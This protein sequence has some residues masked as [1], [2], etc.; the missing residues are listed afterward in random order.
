MTRDKSTETLGALLTRSDYRMALALFVTALALRIPFRSQLAYHWDSAQ[1]A[2]AVSEYNIRLNQPHPPGFYFYIFLARLLNF[3]IGEP[4]AALVWL[5]VIAG[6]GLAAMGYLLATSMFGSGCGRGTGLILLTSPLCWFQSEIA[7]TTIVDG[8]LVVSFVFVCWRAIQRKMTWFQTFAMAAAFAAVGGVRQQSAVLLIPLWIY[9]FWTSAQPRIAKVFCGT[10][11]AAG[12]CLLWFLPMVKS[13]GGIGAYLG[14]VHLKNQYD[15]PLTVWGGG[16]VDALLT[17]VSS[18]G[19]ACWVGLLG[20]GIISVIEFTRWIFFREPIVRTSF[21]RAN[22]TQFAVLVLWITPMVLFGLIMYSVLPGH[23]LHFFPGFAV[24]ASL[25]VAAFS[26]QLATLPTFR[27]SRADCLALAIV[28]A[29]NI[30]VFVWSPTPLMPVLVGLPLTAEEIRRHD[31]DLSKCFQTIRGKWPPDGI[32]ICHGSEDYYWG[33]AQFKY[34]LPEYRNVLVSG[35][36]PTA[37][38]TVDILLVVP[39]GG[40]LEGYRSTFD[41]RGVVLVVEAGAKLYVLRR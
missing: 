21:Y 28:A 34:Y 2:L 26:E 12:F 39:P 36:P 23:V 33:Y 1:L 6:A 37:A 9:T 5:S 18:M 27:K 31:A 3:F 30:I 22:K 19:R 14:L 32:V 29:I 15:A 4:H 24:L 17:D 38:P 13:A 7:L 8:A 20:A 16:G 11:S 41:L 35:S 10:A 40:S 25:G